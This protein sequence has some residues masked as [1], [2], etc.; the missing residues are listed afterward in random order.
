[1]YQL[2]VSKFVKATMHFEID[3]SVLTQWEGLSLDEGGH[4]Q[5]KAPTHH[6]T[7]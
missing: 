6:G 5:D 1:M 3:S 7:I 2:D 4:T